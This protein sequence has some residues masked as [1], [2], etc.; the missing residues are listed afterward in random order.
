[1]SRLEDMAASVAGRGANPEFP[2]IFNHFGRTPGALF[3]KMQAIDIAALFFARNLGIS[4][5][6]CNAAFFQS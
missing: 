5:G 4:G 6:F 3:N 2:C 1:M